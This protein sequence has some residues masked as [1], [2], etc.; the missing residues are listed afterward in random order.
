MQPMPNIRGAV[1]NNMTNTMSNA[2]PNQMPNTMN[3]MNTSNMAMNMSMYC[4]ATFT[5]FLYLDIFP[6]YSFT[7]SSIFFETR[8]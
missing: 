4:L 3:A 5:A 1:P 2:M 6:K 8:A 7:L